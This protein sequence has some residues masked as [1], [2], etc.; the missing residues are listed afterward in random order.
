MT[1]EEK[2]AIERQEITQFMKYFDNNA[3]DFKDTQLLQELQKHIEK[4]FQLEVEEIGY[5]YDPNRDDSENTF[6]LYFINDEKDSR[7]GWQN[8][9]RYWRNGEVVQERPT[10]TYNIGRLYRNLDSLDKETRLKAC[11]TIFQILFHEIQHNRQHLMTRQNVSSNEALRY[12]RDL[13]CKH[14]YL[15]K[16]W[17]TN[18]SKTG[19]YGAYTTEN[20]ANIVGY[21]QY[22]E[23]IGVRDEEFANLRDLEIGKLNIARYKANVATWD[24][25][26]HYD[27][28]GL[29]ERDDVT[30]P[31]LDSLICKKGRVELLQL[32]P[33]LQKEYNMDGTKKSAIDLIKNL[34]Q[35]VDEISNNEN[36]S[37]DDKKNLIKDGQEMYYELIYRQIE[38][39]SPEQIEQIVTQIGKNK[40]KEL[41]ND[42]S[43][44]FQCELENRLGK[45]AQMANAQTKLK[46]EGFIMPFNNGTIEV[47]QNGKKIQMAF[48]D[49]I[50]TINS[51][52]LKKNFLIPSG[53][54]KGEMSAERF[55]E[56]YFFRNLP[57]D[58][59]V[60]LKDGTEISA[61]QYIEQYALQM[62]ELKRNYTPKKF[63]MDT[64]QSESPWTI[65]AENRE[66]LEKYYGD[67][68]QVLADLSKKVTVYDQNKTNEEMQKKIA[69]HQRK[70]DW[71]KDFMKDYEAIEENTAYALRAN[72]ENENIERVLQSIKS[73]KFTEDYDNNATLYKNNPQILMGKIMPSMARLLKEADNLTIDGCTNYLEQF[74]ALPEVNSILLQI[75]KSE[76]FKEMHTKAEENRSNGNLPR[77]H[78]TP[79]EIDKQYAQEY[80]QSN[81]LSE[82][83]IEQEIDYR[84]GQAD[85]S[86]I[87][88]AD[89]VKKSDI[90]KLRKQQ[91]SLT[92]VLA[93]QEGKIPSKALYDSEKKMWYCLTDTR[94]NQKNITP[95]TITSDT[96]MIG[97]QEINSV[98]QETKQLQ[99]QKTTPD[100][101]VSK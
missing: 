58:G 23:T 71:I 57:K 39:A 14:G 70:M 29:Q 63:I 95:A 80:L 7:G 50:K 81:N 84:R 69:S 24:G 60:K 21:S 10:I 17:F 90:S 91:I 12:G 8:S 32:Y 2:I 13:A 4:V 27:S 68:K 28:G 96:S 6:G 3:L 1:K 52:L 83:S 67:K 54:E 20:N 87:K 46:D 73:G 30:I 78:R 19:N 9:G 53:R 37:Q 64:M 48:E 86:R 34:Q 16:E 35:E 99:Y 61:K 33:I 18:D 43:H 93:R 44:Y 77:H 98:V 101:E 15:Q 76:Q 45:S 92:R 85:K 11:K 89:D 22:L 25:Q 41:F 59:K 5:S 97:L 36:L 72:C 82:G 74:V 38:K 79:A 65:Y 51:D 62:G 31:I 56:K 88:V 94:Q 26:L 100:K 55:I 40:S 49:F 47:E 75:K 66:R 42:I